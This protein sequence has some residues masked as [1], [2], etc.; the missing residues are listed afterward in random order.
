[1]VAPEAACANL[2]RLA[3]SGLYGRLRHVRGDRLHTV[4]P[5]SRR[6]EQHRAIVHGAPPRDEPARVF[7]RAARH[8]RCKSAS[9]RIRCSRRRC[10]CCR[11]AYR[12]RRRSMPRRPSR[13]TLRVSRH[14]CR[15]ADPRADDSEYTGARSA[16]AVQRPLPRDGDERG[17][18]QQ[19]LER[20][21]DHPLA[22][23]HDLRQ[24]GNVLLPARRGE[25][26]NSGRLRTSP[27][28]EPPN[29]TRP[30]SP[31]A[32]PSFA[33]AISISRRIPRSSFRPKTTSSC[34]GCASPIAAARGAR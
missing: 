3:E 16:S 13:P 5:A 6:V 9:S 33:G 8:G 15:A 24:L 1:M 11:S 4:A 32:A 2:Q 31:K 29:T 12:A 22:R 14:R 25:R 10:C 26:R 19:P 21:R 34:A 18:R 7:A 28:C 30:S 27:R 20:L 23:R 17:R